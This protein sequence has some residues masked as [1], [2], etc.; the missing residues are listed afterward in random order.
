MTPQGPIIH[1]WTANERKANI[2]TVYNQVELYKPDPD[3]RV[4]AHNTQV[5]FIDTVWVDAEGKFAISPAGAATAIG[6]KSGYDG[7]VVLM[8]RPDRRV[9]L[10]SH[11]EKIDTAFKCDDDQLCF[12]YAPGLLGM[13]DDGSQCQGQGSITMWQADG[14]GA[15]LRNDVSDFMVHGTTSALQGAILPLGDLGDV[16]IQHEYTN[17][18][19]KL[20][21]K[22]DSEPYTKQGWSVVSPHVLT[23]QEKVEALRCDRAGGGDDKQEMLKMLQERGLEKTPGMPD[24]AFCQ[25][26]SKTFYDHIIYDAGKDAA[27]NNGKPPSH[28]FKTK[29]G[30]CGRFS[31]VMDMAC[32]ASGIPARVVCNNPRMG[33]KGEYDPIHMHVCTE[34]YIQGAGWCFLEPQGGD[35]GRM[36]HGYILTGGTVP[37][38]KQLADSALLLGP[39][40]SGGDIDWAFETFDKDKS[41]ALDAMESASLI[42]SLFGLPSSDPDT[43]SSPAI[44]ELIA[45]CDTN[46]DGKITK[47]ELTTFLGPISKKDWSFA[48]PFGLGQNTCGA[49]VLVGA[50]DGDAQTEAGKLPGTQRCFAS[51]FPNVF[52]RS[53]ACEDLGMVGPLNPYSTEALAR[54]PQLGLNLTFAAQREYQFG[55][56]C[57][58]TE[59]VSEAGN[60][61]FGPRPPMCD[62]VDGGGI[63]LPPEKHDSECCLLQ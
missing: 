38:P 62:D 8:K 51:T 59:V 50:T 3:G 11:L 52:L 12:V 9:V 29:V 21:P 43:G 18:E 27:L 41:G 58:C 26:L 63:I 44:Q 55:P 30:Q 10:V 39:P 4:V 57:S 13:A 31:S 42:S 40:P 17:F 56:G 54:N 22:A 53:K 48:N 5:E 15:P 46:H 6:G 35:V 2:R 24:Y 14:K 16:R 1:D 36:S 47:E 7:Q 23:P 61:H 60:G 28:A 49:C 32:R 45:A 19:T 25:R 37:S 34:V 20:I 33:S